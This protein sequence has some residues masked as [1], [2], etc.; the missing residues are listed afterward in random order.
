MRNDTQYITGF[1]NAGWTHDVMT[2]V[3]LIYLGLLTNRV[4]VM[5]PHV[6]M[7]VGV[8]ANDFEFGKIF[9]IP[10]LRTLLRHPVIEW[11]DLKTG[12][13]TWT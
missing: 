5:P 12:I 6:P 7:H 1:L 11:K 8:E 2:L 10:R 3:N 9:D 13:E 4:P